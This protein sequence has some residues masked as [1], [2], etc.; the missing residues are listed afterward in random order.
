[1]RSNSYKSPGSPATLAVI[2]VAAAALTMGAMVI[3]PAQLEFVEAGSSITLAASKTTVSIEGAR[4]GD[5]CAGESINDSRR[6]TFD[7]H[8]RATRAL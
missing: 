1:M 4:A 5:D 8:A 2:S 7:M 3:L 6:P